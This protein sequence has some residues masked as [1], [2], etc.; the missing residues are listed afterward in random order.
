[1]NISY[2]YTIYRY[3]NII[4]K[5]ISKSIVDNEYIKEFC[6]NLYGDNYFII[7][8]MCIINING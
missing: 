7:A 2:I 6:H 1:M 4:N 5:D 8:Y 3:G